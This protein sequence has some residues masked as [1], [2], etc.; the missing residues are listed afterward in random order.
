MNKLHSTIAFALLWL[1]ACVASAQQVMI[2]SVTANGYGR[3]EAQAL[4]DAVINGVAQ[5]NGE[6]VAASMRVTTTSTASTSGGE[7]GRRTIEEDIQRRTRGVVKAWKPVSVNATGAGDFSATAQVSVAVLKRSE[8]LKRMKLAIVPSR[9]GDPALS[10]TL[11]EEVVSNLTTSR[12]F[13]IMDRKNNDAIA[14]QLNR[15]RTGGGAIEDQVRLTGEVA[16]D[17]LVVVTLDPVG[18]NSAKPSV[19]G[20]LEVI[21]Y[22]SRQVKFSEKKSFPFKVG[23]DSSNRRRI[24]ML[25]KG[26]SRAVIQTVYP[27]IV[28]GMDE[29]FITIGQGSDFF[30]K[31]DVLVVKKMGNAIRDPHTGEFLSNEQTEV[32]KAEITYVDERIA[33]AKVSG[34]IQLDPK[35]IADKKYQVWRTGESTDD[36]FV[37]LTGGS[38]G[39]DGGK[40]SK[41]LFATDVDDED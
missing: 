4:S 8:Q 13:A 9:R 25:G 26:L 16:P 7:S 35:L 39:S 40:K 17:F 36:F 6:T 18:R 24:A 38:S 10:A 33:R 37:G 11:A 14:S 3:T 27:P 2:V 5:V 12:K 31:G 20:S 28:V 1:M 34:G 29:G 21:D 19:V 22:S 23:D 30:N 32:G 41:K 15:I